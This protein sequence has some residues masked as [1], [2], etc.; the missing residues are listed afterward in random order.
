MVDNEIEVIVVFTLLAV[1][2]IGSLL[3]R[4]FILKLSLSDWREIERFKARWLW[5]LEP[6]VFLTI[7]LLFFSGSGLMI[8]IFPLFFFGIAAFLVRTGTG[9]LAR[10]QAWCLHYLSLSAAAGLPSPQALRGIASDLRGRFGL[11]VWAAAERVE[12]GGSISEAFDAHAVFPPHVIA[13][14]RI[15]ES[16]GGRLMAATLRSLKA[17]RQFLAEL[18]GRF[19]YRLIL[20]LASLCFTLTAGAF[21]SAFI[22]PKYAE[23]MKAL[24]IDRFSLRIVPILS[25]V[26]L[27]AAA[28]VLLGLVFYVL[29]AGNT[30]SRMKIAISEFGS[31]LLSY[32]PVLRHVTRDISLMRALPALA[33]QLECGVQTPHA[34]RNIA[35]PDISR[36]FALNFLRAADHVERGEVLSE[37]LRRADFPEALCMLVAS[38]RTPE[39]VAFALNSEA[40][41]YQRRVQRFENMLTALI[42]IL[43][44]IFIGI[45]QFTIIWGTWAPFE[46]LRGAL[47]KK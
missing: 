45:V 38:A 6:F 16:G 5:P 37:G 41:W 4:D 10:D 7:G 39:Q 23:I 47:R 33:V 42:P 8:L 36:S 44:V 43:L 18:R 21:L 2:G 32:F 28:M 27:A 31:T 12:L 15:A 9:G 40:A 46:Y 30:P 1:F 26:L 35:T 22:F 11:A 19:S 20:P 25:E 13:A 14:L 34:L 3:V 29:L 24:R 17:E